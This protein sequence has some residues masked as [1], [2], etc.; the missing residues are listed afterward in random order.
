[1]STYDEDDSSATDSAATNPAG[2]SLPEF[3]PVVVNIINIFDKLNLL[4]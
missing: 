2:K 1:M 4:N 3:P